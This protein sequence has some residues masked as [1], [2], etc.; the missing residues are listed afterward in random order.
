MLSFYIN[1]IGLITEEVQGA[2]TRS[3][4]VRGT[5]VLHADELILLAHALGASQTMLNRL[6]VYAGFEHSTINTAKSEVVHFK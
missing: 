2:V 3:Q 6:V 1:D 4:D 5:H